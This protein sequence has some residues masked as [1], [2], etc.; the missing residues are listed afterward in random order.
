MTQ[1][2]ELKRADQRDVG[3]YFI[4]NYPPFSAWS[5]DGVDAVSE[6]LGQQSCGTDFGLYFHIPFCRKRCK[7]CY[8]KV[9]TDRSR[10]EISAYMDAL[11][12]EMNLYAGK[13]ALAGRKPGFIYFGG[14]TPSY[15]SIRQLN[16]M[17]TELSSLFDLSDLDEMTLEG[18]PGTLTRG[19][20]AAIR[21]LGVTRLSLGVE[22][23]DDEILALNGRAHDAAQIETACADAFAA[24]FPYIN[25]DLIA[26]MAGE[27]E[28]KWRAS[29]ARAI[30]LGPTS[31]T[32]YQLEVPHNTGLYAQLRDG[33]V[34]A[35]VA[36]WPT[37]RRWTEYAFNEFEQAGYQ[38]VSSYMAARPGVDE[39]PAYTRRLWRGA[40]MT[41]F[42]VSS[43]SHLSGVH[44]Q[45]EHD[46]AAYVSRVHNGEL[47]VMRA[48]VASADELLIREFVLQL[49]FGRVRTGYF[50]EKFGVRVDERFATPLASLADLGYLT[51]G[52]DEIVISREGLFRVDEFLPRFFLPQHQNIR[53]S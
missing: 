9:Y 18:E 51:V 25:I 23:F 30:E 20:I 27:T 3:N 50:I 45:N 8:F 42:G 53:Y 14:G 40:D 32:I 47:P 44:Y 35:A 48:L 16:R 31:I 37:K 52:D 13:P 17:R 11:I 4:A 24:G 41:G 10:D 33:G 2:R 12:A 5:R 34:S 36:D 39:G 15:L 6:A 49:K 28:Q 7:F 26:G 1:V 22:N 43:F 38:L 29:V 21:E 46:I 19:K